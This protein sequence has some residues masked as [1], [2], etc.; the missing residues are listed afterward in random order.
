MIF[1]APP[2]NLR[3]I[4]LVFSPS[5]HEEVE[6]ELNRFREFGDFLFSVSPEVL[7]STAHVRIHVWQCP[8]S[9]IEAIT[10]RAGREESSVVLSYKFIEEMKMETS[11]PLPD[12]GMVILV[13]HLGKQIKI[14][15]FLETDFRDPLADAAPGNLVVNLARCRMIHP[16]PPVLVGTW[17]TDTLKNFLR[18]IREKGESAQVF[19]DVLPPDMISPVDFSRTGKIV[20]VLED[21]EKISGLP[22]LE[23]HEPPIHFVFLKKTGSNFLRNT[24]NIITDIIKDAPQPGKEQIVILA[25]HGE[26]FQNRYYADLKEL[27]SRGYQ[28]VVLDYSLWDLRHGHDLNLQGTPQEVST[29]IERFVQR[30]VAYVRQHG[31]ESLRFEVVEGSLLSLLADLQFLQILRAKGPSVASLKTVQDM[32]QQWDI[33]FSS[34]RKMWVFQKIAGMK[35]NKETFQKEWEEFQ[36]QLDNLRGLQKDLS[37]NPDMLWRDEAGFES[38]ISV[39]TRLIRMI[40]MHT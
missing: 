19:F 6:N 33:L 20:M 24:K 7:Y 39:G 16:E 28:V 17:R 9:H 18:E 3:D 35:D 27:Q 21:K 8:S 37:L 29:R 14:G 2:E 30:G 25:H 4:L 13:D 5:L 40:Y 11:V 26:A 34:L 22:S 36:R 38:L 23:H 12:G 32:V 15:S 1:P 10:V 31:Y